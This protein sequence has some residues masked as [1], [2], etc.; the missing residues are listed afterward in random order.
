MTVSGDGSRRRALVI[1]G[2]MSGLFAALLLQKQGFEVEVFER[3]EGE[4]AD[5]G[6]GIVAQPEIARAFRRLG[7]DFGDNLGVSTVP[8]RT[9]DREGRLVGET[10]CPQTHT[11]WERVFRLLRKAFAPERYHRGQRFVRVEQDEQGV[12]VHFAEGEPVRGDL[13]IGA[14]GL[15]SNV[16]GQFLPQLGPV[17]A[18]YAAWRALVDEAAISP[19]THRDIYLCMAFALPPGEQILGYPVAGPNDDLR[20][21]HRRYNWVW[22]RPAAETTVLRDLLTDEHGTLHEGSIPP[23]L[24]R[25]AVVEAMRADARR[26]LPPQFQEVIALAR[27]PFLQP[28]YDFETPQMAFGRVAIVG[29]AAF[30]ARPH[31]AGG[32]AKAAEDTMALVD[33][34]AAE[35]DVPAALK[36]FEAA[37]LPIGRRIVAR[38][39]ALGAYIQPE[40]RTE[41]EREN[42]RR[43]S[44]PERVMREIAVLDFL[45]E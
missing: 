36:A 5:R 20:P 2:S 6:A 18:G 12:T 10:T 39:R 31:V 43:H 11:A 26:L 41:E 24:I 42:A 22:Y 38:G 3:V 15:R 9:F 8:R 28:I 19:A 1:G 27:Q 30:V 35:A 14:D 17:Y 25:R 4:L 34:L 32:V 45:Y 21:G 23:P 16:R 44:G 13:L 37:R 29:D 7:I 40:R 33:A